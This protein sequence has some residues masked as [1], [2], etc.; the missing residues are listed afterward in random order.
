MAN[1]SVFSYPLPHVS[2]MVIVA[3]A[4]YP[5]FEAGKKRKSYAAPD[6]FY[7]GN[8]TLPR[9]LSADTGAIF[10]GLNSDTA[11]Y[12]LCDIGQVF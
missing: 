7:Q 2:K 12:W 11:F 8:K 4:S 10:L 1:I 3:S 5:C 9:F 6:S